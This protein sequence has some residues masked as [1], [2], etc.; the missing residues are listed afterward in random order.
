M[1][2]HFEVI[3]APATSSVFCFYTII[4]SGLKC[5]LLQMGA[6]RN[7][8]CYGQNK[9]TTTKKQANNNKSK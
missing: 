3:L 6:K 1:N 5:V 2:I 8:I 7:E 4:S 9:T